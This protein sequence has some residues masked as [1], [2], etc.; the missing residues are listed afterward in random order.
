MRYFIDLAYRGTHYHGWQIQPNALTVQQV[1]EEALSRILRYK[2][3]VTA[4]GRTDTGVH[5]TTQVVHIDH[6]KPLSMS[7]EGYKLNA[8]LPADVA[9]KSIREVNEEAHARF[10]ATSR[11]YEYHIIRQKDPFQ[12]DLSYH[13]NRPLDIEKMNEAATFLLGKQD[14]QSFSKVKT[15]VHT[16]FCEISRAEWLEVNGR[17]VF[18]VSAN[19]FLRG[20]V[21]ALVGT[22]LLIGEEKAEPA[23]IKEVI[24]SGDRGKAGRSV[25]PEGLF[26]TEV[27]YPGEIYTNRD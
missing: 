21:R 20:M 8:I 2:V 17:L 27:A 18:Y 4:S 25:P 14:F 16:Y 6:E 19:R 24:A 10:S 23:S 15:D 11:S 1:V 7:N 22:L 26:L 12:K 3:E 5:A 9:I 13:F